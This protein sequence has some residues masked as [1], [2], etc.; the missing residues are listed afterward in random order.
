[1][2]S[3][4]A[5]SDVN[6]EIVERYEYEAFGTPLIRDENGAAISDSNVGKGERVEQVNI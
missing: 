4:I 6:S 1:M 5:L 2:G 3:V